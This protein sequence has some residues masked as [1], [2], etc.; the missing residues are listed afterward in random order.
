[1][2][3][4]I[5]KKNSSGEAG[6]GRDMT[7][8]LLNIIIFILAA[9]S[10][11]LYNRQPFP[12]IDNF[13][14]SNSPYASY[15]YNSNLTCV[16]KQSIER[17]NVGDEFSLIGLDTSN[18]KLLTENGTF[19]LTIMYENEYQLTIGLTASWT[20]STDIFVLAKETGEFARTASGDVG[21]VYAYAYKGFCK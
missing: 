15:V 10:I 12:V 1:M 7:K 9:L 3:K 18:P 19:P 20:G 2:K 11:Y 14:T 13:S 17:S 5:S 8:S 6:K 21:G 16:I 4:I